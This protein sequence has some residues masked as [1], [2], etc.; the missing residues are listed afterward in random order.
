MLENHNARMINAAQKVIKEN[1][2]TKKPVKY[3]ED[4]SF[5]QW[6][7]DR[8]IFYCEITAL[9]GYNH[10]VR[11][12]FALWEKIMWVIMC[13]IAMIVAL[14]LLYLSLYWNSATPTTTVIESTHFATWNIPF[15]AVT[16]CSVNKI[17]LSALQQKEAEILLPGGIELE[18]LQHMLRVLLLN[19]Y[20]AENIETLGM[21]N[22]I[23]KSNNMT[24]YQM[25]WDL[26]APCRRMIQKCMWK[27]V[28]IRCD[29]I[30]QRVMTMNNIGC[31]SFNF[32][33][34][35][36]TNYQAKAANQVTEPRR[37]SACGFQTGLSVILNPLIDTYAAAAISTYGFRVLTHEAYSLADN[38]AET[39][40][41]QAGLE[42]YIS[43]MPESTYST[44]EVK[45]KDLE[46]RNC[47]REGEVK[48]ET[49]TKYTY[50]NC[51]AEC[52]QQIVYRTCGCLPFSYPNNGSIPYCAVNQMN[53][54]KDI[55][56]IYSVAEPETNFTL[57]GIRQTTN[58]K[59]C[60]CMPECDFYNYLT[61]VSTGVFNRENAF[62]SESFL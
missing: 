60:G 16:I 51:L 12:D 37:V 48:L 56:H 26:T 24:A 32:F 8:C 40:V 23:L 42:A 4:F 17:T 45:E 27:G 19:D 21:L 54:I 31:C 55:S 58:K 11:K 2:K 15:P 57:P 41:V 20:K 44:P 18:D 33:G 47:F 28:Q 59:A 13:I 43:V 1:N 61:E 5:W 29:A 53:C 7:K 10:L 39:K 30:F 3:K 62:S 25:M 34:L 38:N 14:V 6:F 9:H 50:V 36:E 49:M 35:K 52:R 22:Y 46:V